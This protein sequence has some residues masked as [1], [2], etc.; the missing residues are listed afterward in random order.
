MDQPHKR[1][2]GDAG[3]LCRRHPLSAS[4]FLPDGRSRRSPQIP[5]PPPQGQCGFRHVGPLRQC[6]GNNHQGRPQPAPRH[7]VSVLALQGILPASASFLRTIRRFSSKRNLPVN[8]S[9][10]FFADYQYL[11][12]SFLTTNDGD[13]QSF[14]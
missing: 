8:L 13:G 11:C 5:A 4:V 7:R 3:Q 9:F 1:R 6:Q 12:R 2:E 10:C 14:I